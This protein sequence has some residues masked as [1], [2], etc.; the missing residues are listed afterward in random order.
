MPAHR[1][2]DVDATFVPDLEAEVG[3]VMPLQD[4]TSHA[5]HAQPIT[6]DRRATCRRSIEALCG[7]PQL[8]IAPLWYIET[9]TFRMVTVA[10]VWCAQL[11]GVK[12]H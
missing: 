10:S 5:P 1:T 2:R 11:G 4:A 3:Q 7:L 6:D 8:W 9:T 12:A